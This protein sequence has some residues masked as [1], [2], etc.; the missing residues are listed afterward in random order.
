MVNLTFLARRPLPSYCSWDSTQSPTESR[1]EFRPSREALSKRTSRPSTPRM[2]PQRR[3]LWNFV[4]DPRV[5]FPFPYFLWL[6]L[7]FPE[8]FFSC[9][10][11]FSALS[12]SLSFCSASRELVTWSSWVRSCELSCC[13]LATC[14]LSCSFSCRAFL[15][16][17]AVKDKPSATATTKPAKEC[18]RISFSLLNCDLNR[19]WS[20]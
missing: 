6:L 2:R 1:R 13:V 18:V 5:L 7:V 12:A 14:A 20:L 15:S 9:R 8:G 16:W 10:A 4:T 3:L 11:S 19:K 17:H